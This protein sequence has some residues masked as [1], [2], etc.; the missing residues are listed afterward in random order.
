VAAEFLAATHKVFSFILGV[1][2]NSLVRI[3][4]FC[5]CGICIAQNSEWKQKYKD[6]SGFLIQHWYFM[7]QMNFR[8]RTAI[9]TLIISWICIFDAVKASNLRDFK[10]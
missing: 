4:G 9:F 6:A 10:S 3:G 7:I 1:W 2:F 5:Q 8:L